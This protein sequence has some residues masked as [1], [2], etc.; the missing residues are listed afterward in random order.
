MGA[1]VPVML[2]L[3]IRKPFRKQEADRKPRTSET[4]LLSAGFYGCVDLAGREN[5]A[6]RLASPGRNWLNNV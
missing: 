2:R 4:V 1:L 6:G 5:L 3:P